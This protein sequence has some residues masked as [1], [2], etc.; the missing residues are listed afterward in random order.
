M[1]TADAAATA[2]ATSGKNDD[3]EAVGIAA[4]AHATV[5]ADAMLGTIAKAK[6]PLLVN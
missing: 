3:K 6:T 4:V 5:D 1:D 2:A